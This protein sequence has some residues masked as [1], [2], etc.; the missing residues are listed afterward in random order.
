MDPVTH[1]LF[2]VILMLACYLWGHW[3][4]VRRGE[5]EGLTRLC[6]TIE[7]SSIHIDEENGTATINYFDGE[8]VE[9]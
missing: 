1:T 4:G 6:M 9:L 7:A 3:V 2:T 5:I 8:R